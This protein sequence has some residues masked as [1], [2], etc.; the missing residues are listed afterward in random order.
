MSD[1]GGIKWNRAW[2]NMSHVLAGEYVGFEE[3]DD[4]EWNL[5]FGRMKLGR[6]HERLNRIE[7]AQGRLSRKGVK[8]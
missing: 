6:Y 2:V 7:D 3:I 1:N 5:Y 4:G 8:V